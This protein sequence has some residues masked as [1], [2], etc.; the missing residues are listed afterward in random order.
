MTWGRELFQTFLGDQAPE[1]AS[2][3]PERK[4]ELGRDVPGVR[5]AG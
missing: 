4:F 5:V 3:C 2:G 1:S